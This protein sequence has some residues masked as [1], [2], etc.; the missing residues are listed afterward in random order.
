S[1]CDLVTTRTGRQVPLASICTDRGSQARVKIHAPVVREYADAMSRQRGGGG[2]K[3]PPVDLFF[4]GRVYWM[5]ACFPRALASEKAGL[6]EILADVHAGTQRDAL[7]F[8]LSANSAHGLPRTNA[9]KRKAVSLLLSDPEWSQ[10]SDREIARQCQVS[11]FLVSGMRRKS[12]V[13]KSQMR[14]R[15][16]RRGARVSEMKTP[17]TDSSARAGRAEVSPQT[18]AGA[19]PSPVTDSLGIAVAEPMTAVLPQSP[20][21]RLRRRCTRNW[22]V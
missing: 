3:F 15:I 7:L 11:N 5:G 17:A 1:A 2:V 8:S 21:S 13:I 20:T 18:P 12:S 16:V 19:G 9:D 4:D 14:E 22:P 6:K 10:W